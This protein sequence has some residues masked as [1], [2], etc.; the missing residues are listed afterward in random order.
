[1]SD[2]VFDAAGHHTKIRTTGAIAHHNVKHPQ[3][4]KK[5]GVVVRYLDIA[6]NDVGSG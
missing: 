1:M 5:N 2:W 3:T 4:R 6:A